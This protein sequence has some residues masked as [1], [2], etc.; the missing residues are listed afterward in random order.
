M[1]ILTLSNQKGGV[2]KTTTS[3]AISTVLSNKG[4]R[5]LAVDLDPQTNMSFACAIDTDELE[6]SLSKLFQQN[7]RPND[8]EE[9]ISLKDVILHTNIGFDI[10]PGSL[11]L[12]SADMDYTQ[13]GREYML[14]EV[15]KEVS[16]DYDYVIID[17][18][19]TLGILTVNAL[20]ASDLVIIPMNA[21]IYSIQGLSRLNKQIN[22]VKRFCNSR[23]NIGGLL[24]TKY[25]DRYNVSKTIKDI[26][27]KAAKELNTIVF[28]TYIRE[29]VSVKE[30]ALL[31]SDMFK[32]A[33]DSSAILDYIA[34]VDE[35]LERGIL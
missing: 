5:V 34:F 8:K 4:F 12:A 28:D 32:M 21:E 16:A 26:A 23:L 27:N 13:T 15:L 35:I 22:N 10:V 20:A 14:A 9:K 3:I 11:D 7:V 25:Y 2:A 17:T 31:Q 30:A 18:P 24:L 33:P 6:N 19:P 1:K 29:T